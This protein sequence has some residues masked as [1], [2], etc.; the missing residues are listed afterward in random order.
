MKYSVFVAGLLA[1]VA[2]IPTAVAQPQ[3]GAASSNS[4]RLADIMEAASSRHIKLSFAGKNMNWDLA[5]YEA[6][7]L[8]ARLVDAATLYPGLPVTDVTTMA[9]PMRAVS[10]AIAAKDAA[11][12]VKAFN[13]LTDGCNACHQQLGRGFIVMR[14]PTASPFSNQSFVPAKK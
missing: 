1:I 13:E 14:V 4:P 10:D 3:N 2:S 11:K 7:Q 6:A 5:A 12:F 9:T 8:K